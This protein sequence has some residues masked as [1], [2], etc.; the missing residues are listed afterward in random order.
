M[1]SSFGRQEKKDQKER[2]YLRPD[3]VN[4]Q[5]SKTLCVKC[6]QVFRYFYL[7]SNFKSKT[8]FRAQATW[9]HGP[10]NTLILSDILRGETI[11]DFCVMTNS[12]LFA[13]L[14]FL[15][16]PTHCSKTSF[17][18]SNLFQTHFCS[19]LLVTSSE[20]LKKW[21]VVPSYW[22]LRYF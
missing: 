5:H 17:I 13:G 11:S 2:S 3:S 18:Y 22:I 6:W 21:T 15:L 8:T 10:P 7:H 12:S 16:K 4:N 9:L 1:P 14:N 20:T 19:V